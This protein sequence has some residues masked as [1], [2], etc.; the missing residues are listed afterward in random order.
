MAHFY[1]LF[2]HLFVISDICIFH[3][4]LSQWI[5]IRESSLNPITTIVA[6]D[7]KDSSIQGKNL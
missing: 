1:K 6:I 7:L 2:G 5:D 3:F 4:L